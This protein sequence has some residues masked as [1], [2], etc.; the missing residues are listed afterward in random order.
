MRC[1]NNVDL[2]NPE[3]VVCVYDLMLLQA[4]FVIIIFVTSPTCPSIV[5]VGGGTGGM[6]CRG[7]GVKVGH[8]DVGGRGSR[9]R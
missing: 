6:V 9:D 2:V 7:Q 1:F 5:G 4:V 3:P 8:G